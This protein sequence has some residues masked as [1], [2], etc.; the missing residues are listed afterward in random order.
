MLVVVD[1]D[2]EHFH[3]TMNSRKGEKELRKHKLLFQDFFGGNM[4]EKF[5]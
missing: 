4:N 5:D 2:V 1:T 3:S